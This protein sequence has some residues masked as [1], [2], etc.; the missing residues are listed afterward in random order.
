MLSLQQAAGIC[1][2]DMSFVTSARIRS[3]G[4]GYVGDP[5]V[6]YYVCGSREMG[7]LAGGE[8]EQLVCC[9]LSLVSIST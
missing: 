4:F 7:T 6:S 9:H 8:G 2:D 3:R 1:R 5:H